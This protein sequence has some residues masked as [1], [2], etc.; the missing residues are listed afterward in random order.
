VTD[1]VSPTDAV[2]VALL[3]VTVEAE[4]AACALVAGRNP[5]P[6]APMTTIAIRL[7]NVLVDIYF[8]SRVVLETFSNTAGESITFAS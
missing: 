4:I 8:L 7:K 2:A 1:A 5:I 3:R 6:I